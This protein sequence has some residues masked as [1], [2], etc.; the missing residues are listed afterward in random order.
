MTKS[1]QPIREAKCVWGKPPEETKSKIKVLPIGRT[2]WKLAEEPTID[3]IH[4]K[5]KTCPNCGEREENCNCDDDDETHYY[6]ERCDQCRG[7]DDCNCDDNCRCE[8]D[9]NGDLID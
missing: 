2:E 3:N 4:P 8:R 1:Q 6:C 9:E 7:C 5:D